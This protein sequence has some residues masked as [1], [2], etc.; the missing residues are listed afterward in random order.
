L[1]YSDLRQGRINKYVHE[2][3]EIDHL[4][5]RKWFLIRYASAFIVFPEGFR[6]LD[7][8]FEKISLMQTKRIPK[9][10]ISLG[11]KRFLRIHDKIHR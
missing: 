2:Y 7:E 9:F 1:N 3:I 11:W 8:L 6:P 10:P 4:F 5:T